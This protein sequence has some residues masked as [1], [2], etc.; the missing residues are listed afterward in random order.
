MADEKGLSLY[1][2]DVDG[3][4]TAR[5]SCEGV[6]YWFPNWAAAEEAARERRT[7]AMKPPV[8]SSNVEPETLGW[9]TGPDEIEDAQPEDRGVNVERP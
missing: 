1:W 5:C 6:K 2:C 3:Y 9:N 4:S 8:D 7:K